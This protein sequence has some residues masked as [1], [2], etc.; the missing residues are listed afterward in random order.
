MMVYMILRNSILVLAYRSDSV[1]HLRWTQAARR[2]YVRISCMNG[3]CEC[4]M[5]CVMRTSSNL[6]D[7]KNH[8]LIRDFENNFCVAIIWSVVH[9]LLQSIRSVSYAR[10]TFLCLNDFVGIRSDAHLFNAFQMHSSR[11]NV[12]ISYFCVCAILKFK[13]D[14]C[15]TSETRLKFVLNLRNF[16]M[17][18]T[19]TTLKLFFF[20]PLRSPTYFKVYSDDSM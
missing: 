18:T 20:F 16:R 7:E 8:Q 12:R 15:K 3:N 13:P 5:N 9:V 14:D 19:W 4:D 2:T 17:W 6:D 1:Q 11:F 10:C